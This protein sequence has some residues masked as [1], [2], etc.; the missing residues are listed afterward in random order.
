MARRP[1]YEMSEMAKKFTRESSVFVNGFQIS[2]GDM[3]KVRG[4]YGSRFKFH[5]FVTNV[6]TGAQWVDCFEVITGTPSV[7]RSFKLDRIKRI[8]NKGRRA[9][10][11]VD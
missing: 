9:K 8:P 4:E 3:F 1:K 11:V 6:E 2:Y 10:R 7:Y 5:S